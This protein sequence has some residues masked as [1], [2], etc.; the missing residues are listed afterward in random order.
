MSDSIVSDGKVRFSSVQYPKFAN[1]EPNHPFHSAVFQNLE[2]NVAFRFK[3]RSVHVRTQFECKRELGSTA[4]VNPTKDIPMCV[5]AS[6]PPLAILT[7]RHPTPWMVVVGAGV[8][9]WW[10]A[11]GP[12]Q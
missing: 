9:R 4:T 5:L 12:P 2:R 7:H 3:K 1:A 10:L 6:V 8:R 11:G